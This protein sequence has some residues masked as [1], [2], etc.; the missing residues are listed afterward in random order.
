MSEREHHQCSGQ[1]WKRNLAEGA[2][3]SKA[4]RSREEQCT[5]ERKEETAV[6]TNRD[7]KSGRSRK[8]NRAGRWVP[9]QSSHRYL[10]MGDGSRGLPAALLPLP[11]P[12]LLLEDVD[13]KGCIVP[14]GISGAADILLL[15]LMRLP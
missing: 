12:C 8:C 4:Q 5:N 14:P 1:R 7:G 6:D 10:R 13:C 2:R 9:P 11:L 3:Q 15:P